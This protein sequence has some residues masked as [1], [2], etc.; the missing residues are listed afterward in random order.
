MAL[1]LAAFAQ[2][3]A[4]PILAEALSDLRFNVSELPSAI[5][6]FETVLQQQPDFAAPDCIVQVGAMPVGGGVLAWLNQ[7]TCPRIA[8]PNR[9]AWADETYQ[10]ALLKPWGDPSAILRALAAA[11]PAPALAA[12]HYYQ[13]WQV[14]QSAG[15]GGDCGLCA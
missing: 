5:D 8:L 1:A 13:L 9:L 6:G 7:Q 14:C 2:P 10:T 3:R 15:V 12:D 4:I 11:W